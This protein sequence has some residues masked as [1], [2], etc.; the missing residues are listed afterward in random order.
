MVMGCAMID[1]EILKTLSEAAGISSCE[2]AVCSQL[3]TYMQP[4]VDRVIHDGLG[5]VI[6]IK[7]DDETGPKTMLATHAD[8]VGFFVKEIEASGT[9]RLMPVGS[10]WT[11]MLLGHDFKV[12]TQDGRQIKGFIGSPATHGMPSEQRA[13]TLAMEAI[14][15]DLGVADKKEAEA[16]GIR[17]GDM[18]VP[19]TNFRVMNNPNY[20]AGKAFDNRASCAVGLYVLERLKGKKHVPL[21]FA[22]TVQ[23]EPGLRGA[24]TSTDLMHPELAFAIDTTLAGDTPANTNSCKLGGGVVIS[25]LDSNTV[26]HRGL[27]RYVEKVCKEQGIP[28]QYAV[29]NGGG[30]DSGNIHKSFEGIVNMT[31]SIPI[32]YMHTNQSIIHKQDLEACVDLL[33]YILCTM[34]QQT[35][36][37]I[38]A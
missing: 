36:D 32:R 9:L 8:E 1:L 10:W 11:H 6:G 4:Y 26:Y 34:D 3:E 21:S 37:M 17:I 13:K 5:S 25:M 24:R 2:E 14:Y 33:T 23:E 29:F 18:V 20:L 15:L 19:D 12:I 31:L 7:G 27:I 16:L 35:F 38:C 28:Y 30:T 22:C